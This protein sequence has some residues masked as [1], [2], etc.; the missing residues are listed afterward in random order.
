MRPRCRAA[1]RSAYPG[2]L[3]GPWSARLLVPRRRRSRRHL[4][5]VGA[6]R[7]RPVTV[8]RPLLPR[9]ESRR[10]SRRAPS[11]L[12]VARTATHVRLG[13]TLAL[14]VFIAAGCGGAKTPGVATWVRCAMPR[15]ATGSGSRCFGSNGPVRCSPTSVRRSASR[16]SALAWPCVDNGRDGTQAGMRPTAARRRS[17][18]TMPQLQ[19]CDV[20]ESAM[21]PYHR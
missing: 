21:I 16:R 18:W 15:E 6:R 10:H 3:G 20:C 12:A 13:G 5:R 7:R 4:A 8:R 9:G 1:G 2:A 11:L 17:S 19:R 14:V